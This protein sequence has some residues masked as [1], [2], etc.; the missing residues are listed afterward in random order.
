MCPCSVEIEG[1][2]QGKKESQQSGKQKLQQQREL[3]TWSHIEKEK[4]RKYHIETR[5]T[6]ETIF[7]SMFWNKKIFLKKFEEAPIRK[8][9]G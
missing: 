4:A 5:I 7:F 9:M 3:V 8:N 1:E 2:N 6:M